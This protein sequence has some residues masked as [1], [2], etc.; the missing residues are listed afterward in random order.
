MNKIVMLCVAAVALIATASPGLAA[1][2]EAE[3][4]RLGADLTPIG[5]ERA[6]NADGTIPAWDGGLKTMLPGVVP[7]ISRPNP[8]PDEKPLFTIRAADVE[9]YKDKLTP[10]Q[11]AMLTQYAGSFFMNVYPSHRTAALPEN[12]YAAIREQATKVQLED[13]GYGLSGLGLSTV[14]FP[15]PM[16]GQE[17]MWNHL[18]RYRGQAFDRRV[19]QAVVKRDGSFTPMIYHDLL[20]F[21]SGV[22]ETPE[23]ADIVLKIV[24]E[25]LQPQQ[26]AGTKLLGIDRLNP[27]REPRKA[28]MYNAGARRVLRAPEIAYDNPG[29]GADGARTNDNYEMFNGALDRY[30][31]KLVGKREIYIPYNANMLDDRSHEYTDILKPNHLNPDLL[32]YEL[33]RVWVVEATLKE[34]MRHLYSRRVYYLDEDSWSIVGGEH[35]DGRGELWRVSEAHLIQYTEATV[36]FYCVEALYDLL[37]GRYIAFGMN[38]QEPYEINFDWRAD[39]DFY[40]PSNLRRIA[41]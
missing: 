41:N 2:T 4:A 9:R 24:Q 28:W 13:G 29:I 15:V 32:R 31:W 37:D 30:D 5:A 35:Y 17:A 10:G 6:G 34:G 39:D 7:G 33:H 18:V 1:T 26:L 23:N 20:T 27:V 25:I 3:A 11:I 22:P 14:P 12:V 38:N 40:T 36:P 8:F 16:T 19:V 21:R